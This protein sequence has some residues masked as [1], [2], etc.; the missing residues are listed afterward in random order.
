MIIKLFVLLLI[1]VRIIYWSITEIQAHKLKPKIHTTTQLE[2]IKRLVVA[3]VGGFTLLQ[4]MGVSYWA[5][6][7]SDLGQVWGLMLVLVSVVASIYARREIGHNWSHAAEYQIKKDHQ[8]VKTGI[9][10][11]IRHPIY[12]TLILSV[13]G[14]ELVVGSYLVVVFSIALPVIAYIQARREEALLIQKFG[15]KYIDYM[16]KTKMFVPFMW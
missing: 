16:K 13:V 1:V 8:L 11:Y 9:Y 4:L 15:Q 5:Y 6:D 3:A 2:L 7:N 10:R 14:T 12:T